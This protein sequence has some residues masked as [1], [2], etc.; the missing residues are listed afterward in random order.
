MHTEISGGSAVFV[1]LHDAEK[2]LSE[3]EIKKKQAY[4]DV[5]GKTFVV[6]LQCHVSSPS[7]EC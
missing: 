6:R 3:K 7:D 5:L 1:I 4:T 2:R